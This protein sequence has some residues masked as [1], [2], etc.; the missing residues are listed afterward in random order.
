[1]SNAVTMQVAVTNGTPN[2]FQVG[3]SLNNKTTT[4]NSTSHTTYLHSKLFP[5]CFVSVNLNVPK[6]WCMKGKITHKN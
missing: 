3:F 4:M 6:I 5:T 2:S 1:M